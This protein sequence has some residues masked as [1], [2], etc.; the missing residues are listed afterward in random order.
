MAITLRDGTFACSVCGVSYP[1]SQHA[2]ACRD[3]HNLLYVPMSKEE[4]NLLMNAIYGG[5]VRLIPVSLIE[6]LRKFYKQA[7]IKTDG[8]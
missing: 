7:V 8:S 1:S 4:L 3:A 6:T 2:D 5:D